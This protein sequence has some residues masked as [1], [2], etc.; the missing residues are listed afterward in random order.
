MLCYFD[1]VFVYQITFLKSFSEARLVKMA[2]RNAQFW[3]LVELQV[4]TT[5]KK[6]I[7]GVE[8]D[9]SMNN[10]LKDNFERN[11]GC[12]LVVLGPMIDGYLKHIG[13]VFKNKLY[14]SR[15]TRLLQSST[16][17]FPW[18]VYSYLA[19]LAAC[20]GADI[21][22]TKKSIDIIITKEETSRKLWHPRRL[23][24]INHLTKRNFI[25]VPLENE[26]QNGQRTVHNGKANIVVTVKTPVTIKCYIND[27]LYHFIFRGMIALTMQ[28]MLHCRTS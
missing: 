2:V 26:N 24:G 23:S 9:F 13:V 4:R 16:F 20:Y 8:I 5:W 27:V 17:Y 10:S 12:S 22:S 18:Q 7:E 1:N 11:V 21:L 19:K 25:R 6:E 3:N 14:R 15:Q 28:L